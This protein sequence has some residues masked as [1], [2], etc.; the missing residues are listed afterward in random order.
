MHAS[1]LPSGVR[2]CRHAWRLSAA[3]D[4]RRLV[5]PNNVSANAGNHRAVFGSLALGHNAHED[6]HGIGNMTEPHLVQDKGN[7]LHMSRV[8]VLGRAAA[9]VIPVLPH[10]PGGIHALCQHFPCIGMQ[11]VRAV[12]SSRGQLAGTAASRTLSWF[13][14]S[15]KHCAGF[16]T[17][18][19][20]KVDAPHTVSQLS[21]AHT[22]AL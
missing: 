10:G 11:A 19:Q 17:Q 2:F 1:L 14:A 8:P 15:R 21:I 12:A 20:C 3:M 5:I 7:R 4:V 22:Q 9:Q 16:M 18:L 13:H 6:C